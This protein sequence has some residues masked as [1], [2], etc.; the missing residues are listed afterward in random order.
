[1]LR[2]LD[3]GDVLMGSLLYPLRDLLGSVTWLLSYL[4]ADT[5]YHGTHFR[6]MADGRLQRNA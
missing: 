1:M 4:P 6:I 3:A 5:R 2:T